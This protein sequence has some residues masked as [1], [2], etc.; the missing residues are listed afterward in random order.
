MCKL[1]LSL[2]GCMISFVEAM[3]DEVEQILALLFGESSLW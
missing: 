2:N 3:D 1:L